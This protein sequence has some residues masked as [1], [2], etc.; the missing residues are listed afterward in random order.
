MNDALDVFLRNRT[1]GTTVRESVSSKGG[2]GNNS[3]AVAAISPDG[4]LIAFASAASNLVAGDTNHLFDV[5]VHNRATGTTVRASVS[6]AN[7]DSNQFSSTGAISAD[8][9][10]LVFTSYASNLVAGDTNGTS[11]VFVRDLTT[12]TTERISV[13]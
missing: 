4:R 7:A 5:F 10:Y 8:D 12:G 9:R 11:D 6:S 1:T 2:Q 3:S 13:P